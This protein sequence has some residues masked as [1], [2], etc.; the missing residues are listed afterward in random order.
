MDD[1]FIQ[2]PWFFPSQAT[3]RFWLNTRKKR[4][5]GGAMAHTPGLFQTYLFT[6]DSS[7]FMLAVFLE[8][9]GLSFFFIYF[10]SIWFAVLFFFLDFLFAAGSHWNKARWLELR[11]QMDLLRCENAVNPYVFSKESEMDTFQVEG[12]PLRPVD[13]RIAWRRRKISWFKSYAGFFFFLICFLAIF[14]IDGFVSGWLQSGFSWSAT[15]ILIMV[16]YIV[17]ALIHIF[18]TGYFGSEVFFRLRLRGEIRSHDRLVEHGYCHPALGNPDPNPYTQIDISNP[19]NMTFPKPP[20]GRLPGQI[21]LPRLPR[22]HINQNYH[23]L[24]YNT[25][26]TCG[27]F[28]DSQLVNMLLNIKGIPPPA[29]PVPAPGVT[30]QFQKRDA[31]LLA[32]VYHQLVT[33]LETQHIAA[34][35]LFPGV[36]L[37]SIPDCPTPQPPIDEQP[38]AHAVNQQKLP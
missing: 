12:N 34:G 32:A 31:F 13:Q 35:A 28:L 1:Y 20:D 5:S 16:T 30:D 14:K 6:L 18:V 17:V 19:N 37:P 11:N 25:L 8:I 24:E 38:P 10:G 26:S 36:P 27:M 33:I 2:R 21:L 9:V 15:P 7:L 29:P 3:L 22:P 4:L 23:H